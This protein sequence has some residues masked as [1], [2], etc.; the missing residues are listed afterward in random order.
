MNKKFSPPENPSDAEEQISE[1]PHLF[2]LRDNIPPTIFGFPTL[3]S[4]ELTSEAIDFEE[5]C[6]ANKIELDACNNL[7]AFSIFLDNI[8]DRQSQEEFQK[9]VTGI[10]VSIHYLSFRSL[11]QL[12]HE[13]IDGTLGEYHGWW[14]YKAQLTHA[15]DLIVLVNP[16]KFEDKTFTALRT[17]LAPPEMKHKNN[18]PNSGNS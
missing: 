1:T 13:N 3:N 15:I 9:I 11:F 18:K 6:F 2:R 16:E 10:P 17:D 14:I 8:E 4:C 7:F 5:E 12:K